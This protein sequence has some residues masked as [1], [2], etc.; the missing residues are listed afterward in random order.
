MPLTRILY[1]APY[2]YYVYALFLAMVPE[3]RLKSISSISVRFTSA[4]IGLF[5]LQLF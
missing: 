2:E 4:C 3:I 5:Y 1:D